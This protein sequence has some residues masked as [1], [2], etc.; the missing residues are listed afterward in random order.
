MELKGIE[1]SSARCKRAALPL[2]YNPMKVLDVDQP[3]TALSVLAASPLI[4]RDHTYG[5]AS[6]GRTHN[7]LHAMQMIS[8]LIYGPAWYPLKESNLR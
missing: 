2:S 6:G 1:P 5:G 4:M 8:Q 3:T 7:L